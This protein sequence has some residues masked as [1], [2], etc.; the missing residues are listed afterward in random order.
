MFEQAV[1][2][3][4]AML[5]AAQGK[6]ATL[7]PALS[8]CADCGTTQM[9]AAPTLGSCPDCGAELTVLGN[10]DLMVAESVALKAAA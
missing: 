4:Q 8:G 6:S 10:S 5:A 9:I 7:S 3:S 1:Q 2:F